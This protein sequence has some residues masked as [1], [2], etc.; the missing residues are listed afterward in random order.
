MNFP[1][2][3]EWKKA[4]KSEMN[5]LA[6]NNTWELVAKPPNQK[7]IDSK[8]LQKIK[9]G[10]TLEEKKKYK[11]QLVAKGFMQR[12]GV[13]STEVFFPVVKYKTIRLV[14][15]LVAQFNYELEQMDVT[16]AFLHGEL[17]EDIYMK[18][19]QGF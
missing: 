12:E 14:L 9:E 15:A 8:W 16:I 1:K 19:P 18:Q 10:T 13:D 17:E 11:A 6:K 7:I 2:S 4:M 5:S 3:S